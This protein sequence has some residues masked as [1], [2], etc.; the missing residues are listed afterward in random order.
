MPE[1]RSSTAQLFTEWERDGRG[2]GWRVEEVSWCGSTNPEQRV[3]LRC[4]PQFSRKLPLWE[5]R[6]ALSCFFCA[7]AERRLWLRAWMA[8]VA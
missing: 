6:L 2:G 4:D 8:M 7:T 1:G 5:R 3:T